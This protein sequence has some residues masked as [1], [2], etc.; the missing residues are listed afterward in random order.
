MD[1]DFDL[2][3]IGSGPAGEK[4]AAEAAYFGKKVALIE[5]APHL[6]GAGINTGTVPSKTLRETALYFSGLLQ[7]GLY[8]IDYSL[9]EGIS[10]K[11]FMYRKQI[12][13]EEEWD[14]INDNLFKHKIEVIQGVASLKDAHTVHVVKAS[15]EEVDLKT[16]IVLIATGSAPFHPEGIDFDH[17]LIHDSDTILEID[18]IPKSM[19]II[20][21]GVIAS[22][23]ASIFAALGVQVTLI[24]PREK[25]L[26]FI[27]D[28]ITAVLVT[29]MEAGGVQFMFIDW[30]AALE[31]HPD[32]VTLLLP[33]G[34]KLDCDIALF[35]AGR[36]GNIEG[37]GLESLGMELGMRGLIKV[38]EQYRTNIPNIYAAGDVIGFPA[39]ASSS[40]EQ[41]RVA[42][43][44]AFGLHTKEA[45][46]PVLPLA[47][48]TIPE[49][50]MAGLTEEDCKAKNIPYLV[51]RA[52]YSKN[53]RGLIIGDQHGMLKLIFSPA[54][55]SLLGV[56]MV[57]ELASE[58]IHI[59]A[60][61][62]E[63]HGT[64]DRFIRAVYNYPTLSEMYKYAAYDGLGKLDEYN[65][66]QKK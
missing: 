30:K 60:D 37:L 56:H 21:A 8:G 19:G 66:S 1:T 53:A 35:P 57:G 38:N 39:L 54:D 4:G 58:L 24:A 27:D 31:A 47:V 49:V 7:R 51:G 14:I 65:S 6:G 10:V 52:Y 15:G 32:H 42:M 48:Y 26:A 22:E 59:G 40:M 23:Y 3:V 16:E 2:V 9:K 50:S 63:E 11:D 45:M 34:Q 20:G 29:G 61:V 13:V 64:I 46:S 62:V 28:E 5:R 44:H 43:V 41:A 25:L 18:T 17:A 36:Q 55:N 33:E 12:V